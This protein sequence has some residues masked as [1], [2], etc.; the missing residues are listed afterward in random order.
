M[1]KSFKLFLA[2]A[3]FVI[4]F[5]NNFEINSGP[6]PEGSPNSKAILILF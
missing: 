2:A 6:I 4:S 3:V 1:K 5:V